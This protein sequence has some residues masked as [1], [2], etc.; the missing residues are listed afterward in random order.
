M[1]GL[2]EPE[3]AVSHLHI[4][5]LTRA[6]NGR[7]VNQ[8]APVP[9]TGNGRAVN[10]CVTGVK[11]R[12]HEPHIVCRRPRYPLDVLGRGLG[13]DVTARV[14]PQAVTSYTVTVIP[15]PKAIPRGRNLTR[16]K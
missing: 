6:G 2:V 14:T 1:K 4:L 3:S 8:C 16:H 5:W 9:E 15:H 13:H 10:Q 11:I 7:A 12:G